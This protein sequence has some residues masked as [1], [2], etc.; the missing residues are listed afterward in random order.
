MLSEVLIGEPAY[1]ETYQLLLDTPKEFTKLVNY[2]IDKLIKLRGFKKYK[3][4]YFLPPSFKENKIH[5]RMIKSH[6]GRE[7]RIARP[8]FEYLDEDD[9]E[10]SKAKLYYVFHNGVKVSSKVFWDK[11]Y[12]QISP[13]RHFTTDGITPIEGENKDR[14]DRK[15]RNPRYNR[16]KYYLSWTK[17]WKYYLFDRPL[18][19]KSISSW[20]EKFRFGDFLT[21][22]LI[23]V[24][25]A[26]DKNQK[27]LF[28][29]MEDLDEY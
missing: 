23:G 29:Y 20:F 1:L 25:K 8:I 5:D 24:P 18:E 2:H 21:I 14:L 4:I 9:P 11:N 28:E 13:V 15:Y 12:I 27:I 19:N 3:D 7:R 17:E 26:L 10:A 6:S 16:N 22:D